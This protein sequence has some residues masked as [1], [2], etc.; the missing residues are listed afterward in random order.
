[1]EVSLIQRTWSRLWLARL[2]TSSRVVAILFFAGVVMANPSSSAPPPSVSASFRLADKEVRLS[3]SDVSLIA[4]SLKVFLETNPKTAT[5]PMLDRSSPAWLQVE[6]RGE[7]DYEGQVRIGLWRLQSRNANLV[8]VHRAPSDGS[9]FG[10]Q[11]VAS[12][13]RTETTWSVFDVHWEKIS[14]R[15]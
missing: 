8:L 1:V 9:E 15:R 4:N 10:I 3:S 7:I 13:R 6:D 11:Y 2:R 12:L 14:Y 5:I